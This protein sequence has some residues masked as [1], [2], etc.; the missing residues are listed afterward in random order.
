MIDTGRLCTSLDGHIYFVRYFSCEFM[1]S[2][3]RNE[4]D[5][6]FRNPGCNSDEIGISDRRH[7]CEAIDTTA[8]P[9]HNAPLQHSV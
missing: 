4:A 1:V 7:L 9:L 6:P 8:Y 2:E 3:G 5:N